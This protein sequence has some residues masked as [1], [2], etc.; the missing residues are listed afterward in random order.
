[1][2]PLTIELKLKT[3]GSHFITELEMA[4]LQSQY[5]SLDVQQEMLQAQAWLEA[6]RSKRPTY[7]GVKRFIV[8]WLNRS[9]DKAAMRAASQEGRSTA[10]P[11]MP[12]PT[13][14]DEVKSERSRR[15]VNHLRAHPEDGLDVD[16]EQLARFEKALEDHRNGIVPE[17][18]AITIISRVLSQARR[19]APT[20]EPAATES[21]GDAW[22]EPEPEKPVPLNPF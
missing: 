6:N 5:P 8:G 7:A 11:P 20:E 19:N 17:D 22:E 12:L 1:M 16:P 14:E 13:S 18:P 21:H 15:L 4:A 3:G 9:H 10:P 2:V